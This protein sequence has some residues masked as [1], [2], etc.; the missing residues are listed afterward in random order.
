MIRSI[1]NFDFFSTPWP[2]RCFRKAAKKAGGHSLGRAFSIRERDG[3][4]NLP[5]H[6]VEL[7]HL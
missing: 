6:R 2:G 3:L 1:P 5:E 7:T 4:F